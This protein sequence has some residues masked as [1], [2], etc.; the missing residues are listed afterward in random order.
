MLKDLHSFLS[1]MF[2]V[3]VSTEDYSVFSGILKMVTP[4]LVIISLIAFYD[5][6]E[7]IFIIMKSYYRRIPVITIGT[8]AESDR[9]VSYYASRQFENLVRPID[10]TDVL[11]AIC[12]RLDI[13][14]YQLPILDDGR[15]NV[16]A[17]DDNASSLRM[18]KVMLEEAGL[19][20]T[21]A[22]SGA[23]AVAAIGRSKP[24]VILLDYEM[25]VCDGKQ[26]LEMLQAD[27]EMHHIPVIF[28][29]G[30]RDKEHIQAVLKLNPAG[31]LLKPPKRSIVIN[32]IKKA[33]KRPIPTVSGDKIPL[34]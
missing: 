26:T 9:F 6:P 22:S 2:H 32:E 16:L 5:I 29:T 15:I 13:N 11:D 28:L 31:Y 27:E 21:L 19:R 24:D 23:K 33:V 7:N 10:N 34:K 20:V 17:V 1:K 12:R 4:D 14:K 25:P 3:Q 18:L 30:V 8:E